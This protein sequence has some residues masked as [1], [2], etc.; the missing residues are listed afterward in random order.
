MRVVMRENVRGGEGTLRC[1]D[2]LEPSECFGKINLC[3]VI[4]IDPGQSVGVHAHGPDA[5]VYYMLKGR[6]TATD[7]GTESWL[8]E[9]DVMLTGDGGTH[10]VRNDG[11][12]KATLMAVVIA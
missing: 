4:E 2:M 6:L 3:A 5:E 1:T 7:N 8:E 12:Q 11:D 9:G 10:S